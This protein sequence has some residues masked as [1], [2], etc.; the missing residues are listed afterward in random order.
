MWVVLCRS[1]SWPNPD[2]AGT[3]CCAGAGS[4]R[5]L[6]GRHLV[7][8]LG[9]GINPGR[10]S[11]RGP[12]AVWDHLCISESCIRGRMNLPKSPA[13]LGGECP[14]PGQLLPEQQTNNLESIGRIKGI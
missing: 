4:S 2:L 11:W 9:R 13:V 6:P 14:T 7:G 5:G 8:I 1:W 10:R 12:G 3:G